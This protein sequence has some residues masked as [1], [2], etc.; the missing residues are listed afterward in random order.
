[1]DV[2]RELFV[3]SEKNNDHD[4][5]LKVLENLAINYRLEEIYKK[6]NQLEVHFEDARRDR[7]RERTAALRDRDRERTA[8]AQEKKSDRRWQ[9]ATGFTTATFVLGAFAVLLQVFGGG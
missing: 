8:A 9:I 1:M 6:V 3:L 4:E 2:E 7:E 5:R